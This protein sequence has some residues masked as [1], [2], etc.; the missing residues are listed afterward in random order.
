MSEH[1]RIALL[2]DCDNVSHTAIEGVLLIGYAILDGFDLGVGILH[3]LVYGV[4]DDA[5]LEQGVT[6]RRCRCL[7]L[8]HGV[9]R[10]DLRLAP[11]LRPASR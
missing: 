11:P 1:L 10:L 6:E 8:A 3:P 2:I 7:V 4:F 9:E 5:G